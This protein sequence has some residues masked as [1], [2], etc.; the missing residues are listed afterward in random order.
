MVVAL[1]AAS[2]RA[3]AEQPPH[4]GPRIA[5]AIESLGT[6]WPSQKPYPPPEDLS[7]PEGIVHYRVEPGD[8]KYRFLHDPAVAM[9]RGVLFVA[10]YNCPEREIVGE[11]LIRCRRS[12]DGGRT[13]SDVEVIAA[14]RA[15]RGVHYVPAQLLSYQGKLY[16]IV[17][18]MEGGHD[19]IKHCAVYFLD[20]GQDQW[21]P[22]GDI[23]DR[24]LPNYAP[25]KMADGNFIMAG[26]TSSQWP[27]KPLI[28]AV[29]I[30]NG[31]TVTDKWT[32]VPITEKALP[33][34][35][36][37]E[38]T[39]I[40]DANEIVAITRNNDRKSLQPFLYSSRDFG[41]TWAPMPEHGLKALDSKLYSGRL[42]TGQYFV[43]FN[44]PLEKAY[45]GTLVIA[46]SRPG[47]SALTSVWKIQQT[48]HGHPGSR[49]PIQSHYP[50]AIE[51]GGN[52]Y[53]AYSATFG[54][55]K[56]CELAVIPVESLRGR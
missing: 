39:L 2:L 14:D 21:K 37:P 45:R 20:E 27:R 50:C 9:H 38:T 6:D 40:V 29:A 49:R 10:W 1:A 17:G 25:V 7:F 44:H 13:W 8:P 54:H 24:F 56:S 5:Q 31:D 36:C 12:P 23:A 4:S 33:N 34:G 42:T 16:A 55:T 22:A 52:L 11:S 51:A 32:V 26:R 47:E 19:Q 43:I 46:V 41:R 18:K 53:V 15:G 3:G 48:C 35:Q 30:S 28:P